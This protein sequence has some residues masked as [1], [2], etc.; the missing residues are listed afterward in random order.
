MTFL[1]SWVSDDHGNLVNSIAHTNAFEPKLAQILHLETNWKGFQGQ[2]QRSR[3]WSYQLT[4]NGGGIH[5]DSVTLR[6]TCFTCICSA[7]GNHWQ[8]MR[9]FLELGI[10]TTDF[11]TEPVTKNIYNDQVCTRMCE[12]GLKPEGP[13]VTSLLISFF[14]LFPFHFFT[15]FFSPRS[16]FA[17]AYFPCCRVGPLM[18]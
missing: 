1:R 8:S 13:H 14:C 15:L 18:P 12:L 17:L 10:V 2:S 9:Y 4:Y 6:L 5:F 16:P 7:Q 11:F 3:S